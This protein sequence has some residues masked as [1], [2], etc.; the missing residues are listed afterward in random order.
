[1]TFQGVSQESTEKLQNESSVLCPRDRGSERRQVRRFLKAPEINGSAKRAGHDPRNEPRSPA[2]SRAH[3]QQ[4][5]KGQTPGEQTIGQTETARGREDD[6]ENELP[7]RS[8]L[9]G[10]DNDQRRHEKE[11]GEKRWK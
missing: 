1:M 8:Q 6:A 10:S 5:W 9:V 3:E 7:N 11:R 2:R 4:H